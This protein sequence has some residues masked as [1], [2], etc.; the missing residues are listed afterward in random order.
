MSSKRLQQFGVAAA[1]RR[2]SSSLAHGD[3]ILIH[4]VGGIVAAAWHC[5]RF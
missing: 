4:S 5:L 3:I 1:N 2:S